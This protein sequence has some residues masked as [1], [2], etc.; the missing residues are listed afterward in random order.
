M[1][2]LR[3]KIQE[4]EELKATWQRIWARIR[5]LDKGN[6]NTKQFFATIKGRPNKT[7]I[8]T[9]MNERVVVSKKE[10]MEQVCPYFYRKFYKVQVKMRWQI[11]FRA[12]ILNSLHQ[13]IVF[14]K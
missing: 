4:L 12:R 1:R 11:E 10:E 3:L 7:L 9:L 6:T 8:S 2:S 5:W 14:K 13:G